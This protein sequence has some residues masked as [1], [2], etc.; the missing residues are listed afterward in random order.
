LQVDRR[1]ARQA[2]FIN[3]KTPSLAPNSPTLPSEKPVRRGDKAE[4]PVCS[5]ADGFG[6]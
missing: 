1:L 5:I 2:H 6:V 3:V 4:P